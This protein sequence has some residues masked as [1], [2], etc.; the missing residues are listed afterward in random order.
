MGGRADKNPM[1]DVEPELITTTPWALH[2]LPP[3]PVVATR[4]LQVLSKKDVNITEVGGI[5]A[6]EPVFASRVLQMANSPLFALERQVKTISHSIVL[7]GLDRVRGI[8]MT[9]AMGDFVNP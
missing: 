3:F 1:V 8:A 2:R 9:R 7:L 6:S 4:L 5:V